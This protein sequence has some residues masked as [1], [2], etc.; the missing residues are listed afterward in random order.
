[1]RGAGRRDD[2]T[3]DALRGSVIVGDVMTPFADDDWSGEADNP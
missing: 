3:L 2:E 1:M